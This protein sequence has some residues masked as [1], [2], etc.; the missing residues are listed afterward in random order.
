MVDMENPTGSYVLEERPHVAVLHRWPIE[1]PYGERVDHER[2]AATYVCTAESRG[3]VPE[4][5]AAVVVVDDFDRDAADAVRRLALRFGPAVRVVAVHELDLVIAAQLRME[6]D[7]AGHRPDYIARFRD[8][9]LMGRTVAAA[10]I[11]CPVFAPVESLADVAG[12]ARRHGYPVIVKPTGDGGSSG[13]VKVSSKAELAARV[14]DAQLAAKPHLAQQYCDDPVGAIDGF[15]TGAAL[16]PWRASEYL[17]TCLDFASGGRWMGYIEIDDPEQNAAL[18]AFADAV[19]TALSPGEPTVFHLEY[20]L[21]RDAAG[22]PAVRFLEIG[23][24]ASGGETPAL[25][26]ELHGFDLHGATVDVQ[27][28]RVPTA[29]G[30]SNCNVAG[31]LLIHPD[32]APPCTVVSARLHLAPDDP[33]PYAM[34]VPQAG[35][36]ITRAFGYTDVGAAFRFSGGS[37]AVVRAALLRTVEAFRMDCVALHA[38][39]IPA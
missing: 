16:G 6:F 7:A 24:R 38:D 1:V 10:G 5:A 19:L 9:V 30:F 35:T 32:V 15:W 34:T 37:T 3:Y 2:N 26:R 25:W 20:F 17:N 21:G 4:Q 23:A 13:V 12:F 36:A 39:A 27:M 22:A 31:E 11:D 8:K 29:V 18:E 33:A 14:S 28:G